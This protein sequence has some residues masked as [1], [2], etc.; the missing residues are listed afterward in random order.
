MSEPPQPINAQLAQIRDQVR[1][2]LPSVQA[3][4]PLRRALLHTQSVVEQRLGLPNEA[5]KSAGHRRK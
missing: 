3:D 4:A 5:P 2:V 1:A